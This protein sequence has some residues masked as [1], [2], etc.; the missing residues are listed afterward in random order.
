MSLRTKLMLGIIVPILIA[1]GIGSAMSV[2][3]IRELARE[4]FVESAQGQMR[5]VDSFVQQYLDAARKNAALLATHPTLAQADGLLTKYTEEP[6]ALDR[7]PANPGTEEQQVLRVLKRYTDAMPNLSSAYVGTEDGGFTLTPPGPLPPNY[8][9]R[10]RSWFKAAM[11]SG[12]GAVLTPAFRNVQGLAVAC[13]AARIVDGRGKATGVCA[14]EMNLTTITEVIGGLKL[15]ATGFV[16]LSQPNGII[17]VDPRHPELEFKTAG[18][19]GNSEVDALVTVESGDEIEMDGS[20]KLVAKYISPDSGWKMCLIIDSDEVYEGANHIAKALL[21]LTGILVLAMAILGWFMARGISRP[22]SAIV[23]GAEGVAQ[24]DYEALP[25]EQ[26]FKAEM[27]TLH[28][29]LKDMVASLVA[30]LEDAGAQ[31]EHAREQTER[32]ER[33]MA[34]AREAQAEAERAKR[35]GMLAAAGQL[36]GIVTQVSSASEELSA[37]VE[38]SNQGAQMQRERTSETATAMEQ[39]NASMLEVA[40]NASEAAESAERAHTEADR[41][42]QLVDNVVRAISKVH[43]EATRMETSLGDL[44]R[45]ADGIGAVMDVIGDI[46]DQTNLLALNAAIE[47]ARAG[48]AGRG[49]AVV[50]DEVRKLAEKTMQAT[51]EVHAAV[52]S[53][54]QGTHDSIEGMAA[55]ARLVE[56]STRLAQGSGESIQTIVGIVTST[57]DQIR[58]IATASEEQSAASEQITRGTDEIHSIATETSQAMNESSHAVNDLARLAG[59]LQDVITDLQAH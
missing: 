1:L 33:A 21:G 54:Q 38:Q 50:A 42:S 56:E 40:R 29:A 25:G 8:D 27:L 51:Q 12:D 16:T 11:Q 58:A 23:A 10:T 43:D 4:N 13:G 49:F 32:A 57:A 24:G 52:T 45:Q 28:R 9:P 31:T 2:Y 53:I 41:G 35:E 55:T 47:A 6:R 26:G 59:N 19:T 20:T 3:T 15:G 36:E 7:A 18:K 22:I 48:D 37:Q 34:A 5:L 14:L 39:M 17:L 30:A 46:A 44:G